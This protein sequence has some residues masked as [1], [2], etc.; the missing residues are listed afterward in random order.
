MRKHGY[1]A[2]G[3]VGLA[4]LGFAAAG[5]VAHG[6]SSHQSGC[7]TQHTCP[8]DHHTYVWFDPATG[9]GWD[10]V[11]P[12]AREYDPSRDTTTIVWE[13]PL[14]T[15]APRPLLAQQRACRPPRPNLR[16][17]AQLRPRFRGRSSCCLI[18]PSLRVRSTQM[19][20]RPRSERRSARAAGRRRFVRPSGTR[21]RSSFSRW[22]FTKR[23]ALLPLTRKIT[24]FHS[25]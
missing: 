14:T 24:S 17:Q 2:V 11:E 19:S 8:S 1:L 4:L 22:S 13:S 9:Q 3:A 7:H 12:G 23:R 16:R 5:A 10:C 6:A 25:S 21:T 15:A 18:Q 20:F